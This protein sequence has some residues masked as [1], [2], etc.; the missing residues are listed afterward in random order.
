MKTDE[1]NNLYSGVYIY[2][3][4]AYTNNEDKF[5]PYSVGYIN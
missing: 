4:E 5:I 1:D 3:L 2:D